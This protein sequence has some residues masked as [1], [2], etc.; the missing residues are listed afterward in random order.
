M[1]RPITRQPKIPATLLAK[2]PRLPEAGPLDTLV[3]L[4]REW[5][6]LHRGRSRG[7][8]DPDEFRDLV[9]SMQT[10]TII[11]RAAEQLGGLGVSNQLPRTG[12]ELDLSQLTD[13]ELEWL[14]RIVEK[15]GRPQR[16]AI[17]VSTQVHSPA[18]LEAKR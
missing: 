9:Y 18:A 12:A 2:L 7:Q 14:E 16:D 13:E 17:I 8:I 6:R 5:Q 15:A 11:T 10:G 1:A 4:Q 3:D